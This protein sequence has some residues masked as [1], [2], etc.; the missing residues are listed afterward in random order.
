MIGG[1]PM[2]PAMPVPRFPA[3][4]PPRFPAAPAPAN[5]APAR[6]IRGQSP[7]EP[8]PPRD[9]RPTVLTLPSPEQLGISISSSETAID[10]TAV[11]RQLDRLGISCFQLERLANGWHV[12]CLVPTAQPGRQQRIEA[13]AVTK[14]EA[15]RL[16]LN[17]AEESAAKNGR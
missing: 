12:I 8:P 17:R 11:H 15:V 13:E 5:S 1:P 4:A 16:V 6:T 7:D 9:I 2:M 10:W 3:I 14:A